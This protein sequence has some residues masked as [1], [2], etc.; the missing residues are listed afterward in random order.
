MIY[1]HPGS[2]FSA[3]KGAILAHAC[4]AQGVWGRGIA[5][6]FKQRFPDAYR[7]Y[8]AA[9]DALNITGYA[10][11]FKDGDY[12]VGCLYTSRYYSPPD[13]RA[14]ILHHTATALVWLKE[15][16]ETLPAPLP[17]VCSNKF[18]SGLFKVPW[19]DTVEV[20]EKF[21]PGDWHVYEGNV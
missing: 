2:L 20:I 21:W 3:P 9:C 12:Y 17:M 19:Q 6:E 10:S 1:Y 4:N 18:N 16:Y 13:D 5:L 15:H 8:T 11:I 7:E 14:K